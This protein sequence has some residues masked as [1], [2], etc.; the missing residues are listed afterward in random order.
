M[1]RQSYSSEIMNTGIDIVTVPVPGMT[2]RVQTIAL[3]ISDDP[4]PEFQIQATVI[5][6][7][8]VNHL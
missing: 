8:I 7:I 6:T 2:C 5:S 1:F 3:H 4:L